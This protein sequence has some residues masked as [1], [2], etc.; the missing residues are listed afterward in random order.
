MTA[1]SRANQLTY[2]ANPAGYS[3]QNHTQRERFDDRYN[4]EN[5][6]IQQPASYLQPPYAQQEGT[7]SSGNTQQLNTHAMANMLKETKDLRHVAATSTYDRPV[8]L[9]ERLHQSYYPSQDRQ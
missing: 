8:D 7:T 5:R 4:Q 1:F 6:N 9:P 2:G 3:T